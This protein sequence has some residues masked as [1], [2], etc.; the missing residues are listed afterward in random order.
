[1][2]WACPLTTTIKSAM[3]ERLEPAQHVSSCSGSQNYPFYF[4][5]P[6]R[7]SQSQ[8]T[9]HHGRIVC[10]SVCY[11]KKLQ[12]TIYEVKS[13]AGSE[14][15][16]RWI[17]WPGCSACGLSIS[18]ASSK[19]KDRWIAWP[20]CLCS[21]HQAHSW[22]GSA[23][24]SLSFYSTSLIYWS[25]SLSTAVLLSMYQSQNNIWRCHVPGLGSISILLR[26]GRFP[27]NV[28]NSKQHLTLPCFQPQFNI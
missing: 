1:M 8:P 27:R 14:N 9:R 15:K 7:Y 20:V 17:A 19:N 2:F 22:W 5:K 11:L 13:G 18:S 23:S 25:K 4:N 26:L 3:Y 10:L 6:Q 16:D 24:L 12:R 28:S 21:D